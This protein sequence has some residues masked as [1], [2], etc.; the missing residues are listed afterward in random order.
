MAVHSLETWIAEAE[1]TRSILN[2][3]HSIPRFCDIDSIYQSS[4]FELSEMEDSRENRRTILK[5]IIENAIKDVS[6]GYVQRL[7]EEQIKRVGNE[8]AKNKQFLVS[9]LILG[10]NLL[11]QL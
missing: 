7:S 11:H 8:F 6:L 9:Q 5:S 3:V 1:R 10:N 2:P 4:K